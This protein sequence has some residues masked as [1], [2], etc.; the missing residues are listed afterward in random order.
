MEGIVLRSRNLGEADRIITLY[1]RERGK[2]EC[3][4]RGARRAR[5]R[6]IG[7]TQLFTRGKYAIFSGRSLDSL[8]QMEIVQSFAPLREDL[9][10]M[11]YA[12]YFA[13]LLDLSVELEEPSEDLYALFLDGLNTLV[14][15]IH[16]EVVSR[17]F[18]LNLMSLLGYTPHL[19]GCI[20]C[21]EA[22]E[23][24]SFMS[25]KEGGL[26]CS[27]CRARD[28]AAVRIGPACL[29]WMR[30]LLELSAERLRVVRIA[31]SDMKLLETVA[32]N[33]VDLRLSRPL[34]SLGFLVSLR[35]LA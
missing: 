29:G 19:D 34:K 4:A 25:A 3:V 27:R 2:I 24:T 18:E 14:E 23:D 1:T 8:S 10:L 17:W 13:E 35:D 11:A 20:G 12:S 31:N 22:L 6:F 26:L 16:P 5:N 32:R 30:R 15:G 9:T 28:G 7:G 33:Y 21:G